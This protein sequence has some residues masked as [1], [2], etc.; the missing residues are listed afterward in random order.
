MKRVLAISI[1]IMATMGKSSMAKSSNLLIPLPPAN[2]ELDPHKMQDAW[3][4]H[5]VMQILLPNI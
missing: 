4:M 3:S 1:L 2:I 5:V